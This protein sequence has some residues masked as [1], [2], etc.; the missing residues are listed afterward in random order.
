[1]FLDA[2]ELSPVVLRSVV[3]DGFGGD[4]KNTRPRTVYDYE[5]EYIID[6]DNGGECCDGNIV[7]YKKGDVV[8][9][10][11]GQKVYSILPYKCYFILM[12]F[13]GKKEKAKG[14]DL[15]T[16]AN[17]HEAIESPV[18]DMIPHIIPGDKTVSAERFF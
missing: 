12:D 14:Y 5:F 18:F 17:K 16:E 9:R 13:T 3:F 7:K 10:T 2:H 11:P 8:F 1:M 4:E 6:T 15:G